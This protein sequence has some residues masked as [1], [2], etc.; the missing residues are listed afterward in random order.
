MIHLYCGD[1]KGKTTAAEGLCL[2]AAGAGIEVVF[3]QFMKGGLTSELH[4]FE[5]LTDIKVIR[6]RKDFGFYKNMSEEDKRQIRASHDANLKEACG[7]V[8]EGR[9]GLL[10]LDEITYPYR[11]GLVDRGLVEG[12][13]NGKPEEMELVLTGRNPEQIFIDKADYIT[14]MCCVRHPYEKGVGARRGIE[15]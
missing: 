6:N 7:L 1:G 3:V 11:L 10:V 4:S 12:L 13:L 9:C 5:K 14:R 2:R 15:Y 8:A